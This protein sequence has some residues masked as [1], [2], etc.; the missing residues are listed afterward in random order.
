[1]SK[2]KPDPNKVLKPGQAAARLNIEHKH[3]PKLDRPWTRGDVLRLRKE[4]P[5]WLTEAR[6]EYA[7]KKD[8][9]AKAKRERLDALLD[10]GGFTRPDDGR[11][12]L[13]PYAET[14]LMYLMHQKKVP[15]QDA[16][17][18]VDR[19]W[20]SIAEWEPEEEYEYF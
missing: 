18:A 17:E 13:I 9:A 10:E 7:A 19:R 16:E 3:L 6:K 4:R 11:N 15:P 8:A 1:M 5:A 12:D 14:A 20:P 2:R